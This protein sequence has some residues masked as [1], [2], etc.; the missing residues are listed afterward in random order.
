MENERDQDYCFACQCYVH[1]IFFNKATRCDHLKLQ[2]SESS[3]TNEALSYLKEH[4]IEIKHI[5]MCKIK[6]LMHNK[7]DRK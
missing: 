4:V 1:L 7:I 2:D 5:D 3:K 6:K